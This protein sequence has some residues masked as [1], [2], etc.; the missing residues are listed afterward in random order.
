M[1]AALG[2]GWTVV[3]AEDGALYACGRG[4]SGQLGI[5]TRTDELELVR[6]SGAEPHGNSPVVLVAAGGHHWAAVLEDGAILTCG[7]GDDGQLGH[8]DEGDAPG[9]DKLRPA[10]LERAVF[11]GAPVVLV[12][13]G[14]AHT[15]AVTGAGRV[16]TS[17]HNS[18]GQLGL[19]N[20]TSSRVFMPVDQGQFE[21]AHIVMAACGFLYSVAVSAE[22]DVF[23][24][25]DGGYGGL[26]HND[27]QVRLL[28][29]RL[30]QGQF[31]GGKVVLVA[32]GFFHTVAL[33]E[34]GMLWV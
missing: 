15:L 21:D 6:V 17:G 28:P 20:R 32:A 13:C 26:G 30:E 34:G 14:Y 25:G 1:A 31:G 5:N 19:G 2:R 3:L 33:T 8:G 18:D 12:A 24:W 22:G 29:A 11:G 9:R 7:S 23:T 4:D 10:R 16:Y 27:Q